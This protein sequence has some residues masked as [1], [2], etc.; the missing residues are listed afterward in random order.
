MCAL[1]MQADQDGKH[2]FLER[3]AYSDLDHHGFAALHYAVMY[4]KVD[5]IKILLPK[6]SKLHY[7]TLN[8]D[9]P[10]TVGNRTRPEQVH[11]CAQMMLYQFSFLPTHP[12]TYKHTHTHTHTHTRARAHTH[13][14][15]HTRA[16]THTHTTYT[17]SQCAH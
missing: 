16:H 12:H 10:Q 17:R 6:C 7:C 5:T 8:I 1:C 11:I 2:D 14:Y 9:I 4:H 13:T 15:T 3:H